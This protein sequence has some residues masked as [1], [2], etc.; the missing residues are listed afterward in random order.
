MDSQIEQF[1]DVN[2]GRG[3]LRAYTLMVLRRTHINFLFGD[4]TKESI[5]Q[6]DK[7]NNLMP[8]PPESKREEMWMGPFSKS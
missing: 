2:M 1:L 7:V 6:L 5:S 3:E 4:M 8:D